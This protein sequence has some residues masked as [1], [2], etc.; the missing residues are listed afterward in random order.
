MKTAERCNECGRNVASRSGLFVDRTASF[1]NYKT[2]TLMGKPFP[3]G[4][5]MCRE[6]NDKVFN[7]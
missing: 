1:D 6:C 4:G 5:F 2:Q 3:N 7:S